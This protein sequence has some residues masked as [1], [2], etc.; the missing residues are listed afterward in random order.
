MAHNAYDN[1]FARGSTIWHIKHDWWSTTATTSLYDS[2][3]KISC[4]TNGQMLLKHK[5]T[6]SWYS[7]SDIR[8]PPLIAKLA[9]PGYLP[10]L[11]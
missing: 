5:H 3:K 8:R 9:Q 7:V 2:W 11:E 10:A 1:G 6:G 4:N